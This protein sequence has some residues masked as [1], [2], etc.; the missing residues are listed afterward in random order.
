MIYKMSKLQ[1]RVRRATTTHK[2]LVNELNIQLG[3]PIYEQ[4]PIHVEHNDGG[5]VRVD[6]HETT[7]IITDI[8]IE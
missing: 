3:N 1:Y 6:F 7:N 2:E 4:E 8:V 5:M